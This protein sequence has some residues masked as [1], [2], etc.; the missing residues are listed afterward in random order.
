[1][2]AEL[3]DPGP[4]ALFIMPNSFSLRTDAPTHSL[5]ALTISHYTWSALAV[6]KNSHDPLLLQ[7]P[8]GFFI[9]CTA[10]P[11]TRLAI[12]GGATCP[13]STARCVRGGLKVFGITARFDLCLGLQRE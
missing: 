6:F 3:V 8:F 13:G 5:P 10:L 1:M 12:N 4:P 9:F 2:F 7:L 11:P